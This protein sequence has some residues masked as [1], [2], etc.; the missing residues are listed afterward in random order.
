MNCSIKN[1]YS[2]SSSNNNSE[3]NLSSWFENITFNIIIRMLVGKRSTGCI[4]LEMN[5]KESIK[6]E[7]YLGGTSVFSDAIPC[8]QWMDISGH[9]KSMK[10]TYKEVGYIGG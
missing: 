4:E 8:I 7:L 3:V 6:K 1:L 10:Q 9:I 2:N 5:F